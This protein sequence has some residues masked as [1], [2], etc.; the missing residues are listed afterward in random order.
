MKAKDLVEKDAPK[1]PRPSANCKNRQAQDGQRHPVPLS[2]PGAKFIF[3][4][5]WNKG[6]KLA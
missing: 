3:A 4:E 1:Q 2:D 6:K 5:I